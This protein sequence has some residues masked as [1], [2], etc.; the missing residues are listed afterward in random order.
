VLCLLGMECSTNWVTSCQFV[1]HRASRSIPKL[2]TFL[3]HPVDQ[4]R[5]CRACRHPRYKPGRNAERGN[6]RTAEEEM[7]PTNEQI[8]RRSNQHG[9]VH[10]YLADASGLLKR[11]ADFFVVVRL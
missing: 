8:V 7:S 11:F 2:I 10:A 3:V 5:Q 6:G 9:V 4:L 1:P